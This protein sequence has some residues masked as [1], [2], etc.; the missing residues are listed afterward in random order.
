[1]AS[2]PP[3]SP[4]KYLLNPSHLIYQDSGTREGMKGI[5]LAFENLKED[6]VETY[7][8]PSTVVGWEKELIRFLGRSRNVGFNELVA[9]CKTS[10]VVIIHGK[11]DKIIPVENS[12]RLKEGIEERGGKVTLKEVEGGHCWHE[13][14][15]RYWEYF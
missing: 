7:R 11:N 14:T 12:R 6:T 1:M 4:S 9:V 5:S 10:E 2:V 13:E 15:E 8:R 3:P